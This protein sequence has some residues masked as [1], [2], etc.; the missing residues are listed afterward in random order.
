MNK[1]QARH[2]E[3]SKIRNANMR[4]YRNNIRKQIRRAQ[5]KALCTKQE[6]K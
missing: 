1:R 4:A 3:E 6:T 2:T 5:L